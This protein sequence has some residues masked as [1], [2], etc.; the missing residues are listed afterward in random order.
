MLDYL[1]STCV[2]TTTYLLPQGEKGGALLFWQQ[3]C[4]TVILINGHKREQLFL[5]RSQH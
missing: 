3:L 4:V 2:V 5:S 1:M